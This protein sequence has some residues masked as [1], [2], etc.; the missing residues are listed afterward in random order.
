MIL[1][2][3]K[4]ENFKCVEDSGWSSL[5]PVTCLVGK[6]ESGKTALL[7]ALYKLKPCVPEE[8]RFDPI[9]E[10]PRRKWSEYRTRHQARPDN[11][12]TTVWELEKADREALAAKFG[13]NCLRSSTVKVKKGYD[14]REYWAIPI[15]EKQ[16]AAQYLESYK[17]QQAGTVDLASMETIPEIIEKLQAIAAPT[18]RESGLLETLKSH[19][20]DGS[21]LRAAIKILKDRLPAFVYFADYQTMP[22]VVAIDE[23]LKKRAEK[24]LEHS[25]RVFLALLDLAGTTAEQINEISEFEVLIAELEAVSSHLTEE[26]FEYWSQNK[27]LAVNFRFDNARPGDPPPYNTGYIFRTRIGNKRHGVTVNFDERSTGFVWFFSFLVWFSQV[28]KNFGD[29]LVILLDDP[30]LG[31]HARAQAD[32]LR[33]INEKLKPRYQVIYTTHSPFMIDPQ[34]LGCARTVEDVTT[35]EKI[36]GTK[37]G[38]KILSTDADTLFPLQTALRYEIARGLL[39]RAHT[40]LVE[41][42][43]DLL[44]LKWFSRELK[45]QKRDHLDPRWVISPC[46]GIYRVGSFIALFDS[47]QANVV[48]FT[49]FRRGLKTKVRNIRGSELLQK[50]HVFSA[51]MYSAQPEADIEDLLGRSLYLTLVNRCYS[52]EESQ[53]LPREK[54]AEAPLRVVEEVGKHFAALSPALPEFDHSAPASFLMENTAELRSVLPGLDQALD[55]FEKLFRD[56]NKLLDDRK[57]Q[58]R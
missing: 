58:Q 29:D 5:A 2:A 48:V 8:S 16:V 14:N 53:Q 36:E 34:N 1:K 46:G 38:D 17:L 19:F 49:S 11:V 30:G 13:P 51:E 24:R 50:G 25:D 47:D 28:R 6:N 20:P 39:A 31:L 4:V 12:L 44:Y 15:D 40:L 3:I 54:P 35:D 37:V 10:Y 22:G 9:L 26:I 18:P 55:R 32:M 23:L 56:V 33:Y 42:D 27:H 41:G 21:T 57:E 45:A 43:S 52:L 7:Q